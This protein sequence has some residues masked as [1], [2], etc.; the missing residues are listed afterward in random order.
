[1]YIYCLGWLSSLTLSLVCSCCWMWFLYTHFSEWIQWKWGQCLFNSYSTGKP[2]PE[3]LPFWIFLELR[4]LE[5]VG[6][7]CFSQIV[8]TSKPTPGF[9][10][11]RYVSCRPSHTVKSKKCPMCFTELKG[12]VKEP[13]ML[14]NY[15]TEKIT[16]KTSDTAENLQLYQVVRFFRR[17]SS[18][19]THL[20]RNENLNICWYMR[21]AWWSL[22]EE[23]NNTL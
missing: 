20:L 15:E 18:C 3:C 22:V 21:R 11:A 16:R 5:M 12:S 7:Q 9:L 1:M 17:R 23:P 10:E 19:T 14:H 13:N 2:V 6:M 4:M 8:T